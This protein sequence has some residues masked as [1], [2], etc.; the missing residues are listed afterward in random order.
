MSNSKDYKRYWRKR[1]ICSIPSSLQ[2]NLSHYN[3]ARDAR[4]LDIGCGNA[5]FLKSIEKEGYTHL[6]GIDLNISFESGI[7]LGSHI[8][9]FTQDA[10]KLQFSNEIFDVAIMKALLTV[11]VSDY[12]IY[13]IFKEA[14]RVLKHGGIL[15]IKDFFQNWHLQLYRRRYL[16]TINKI[17][18]HKCVFPVYDETGGLRY[19]ARHFNTQELS[20]MLIKIGFIIENIVFEKVKTQSGNKVIGFTIIAKKS[21]YG[22]LY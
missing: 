14:Y 4:V 5:E 16:S 21:C 6:V 2:I 12:S 22:R 11:V 1:N 13:R 9:L 19:Y 3:I 8:Q 10:S 18:Q 20:I 15:I 17:R 7:N